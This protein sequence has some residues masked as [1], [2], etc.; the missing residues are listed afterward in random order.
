MQK[1]EI[2]KMKEKLIQIFK[3]ESAACTTINGKWG[4]G[5]TYFWHKFV[6]DNSKKL[7][8]WKICF[9]HKFLED[10]SNKILNHGA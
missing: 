7:N 6:E 5:K 4:V 9:R 2:D 1:N 3:D 10:N 8:I